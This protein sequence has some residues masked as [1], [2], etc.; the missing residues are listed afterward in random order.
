MLHYKH[1]MC[2]MSL[3][4]AKML[5]V[6]MDWCKIKKLNVIN[7]PVGLVVGVGSAEDKLNQEKTMLGCF[8]VNLGINLLKQVRDFNC[9]ILKENVIQ[10]S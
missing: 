7:R 1:T 2:L 4:N 9:D 5:L 3:F 8:R 10:F 6:I